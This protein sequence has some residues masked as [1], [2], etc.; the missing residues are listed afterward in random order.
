[1]KLDVVRAVAIERARGLMQVAQDLTTE[2]AAAEEA[3]GQARALLAIVEKVDAGKVAKSQEMLR[4]KW[5]ALIRAHLATGKRRPTLFDV[6][7]EMGW[8]SEQPLRDYCRD[9][10]VTNWHDVHPI[11]AAA[12]I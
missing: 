12:S 11:V 3:R 2:P 6:A 7:K 10:G 4:A 8:E 9:L 5:V 1:M